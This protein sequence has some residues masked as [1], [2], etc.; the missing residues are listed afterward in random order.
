[1]TRILLSK[2]SSGFRK[3]TLAEKWA[4]NEYERML[5]EIGK[6]TD[7]T[8]NDYALQFYIDGCP[9]EKARKSE[10]KS[11][12]I[13]TRDD[14]R[15]KLETH[16]LTDPISKMRL[17]DIK[18]PDC[19]N[20]RD[21]LIDKLG[22]SR[23]AELSL[24]TFRNVIHEALN[25]GLINNDPTIK[26]NIKAKKGKRAATTVEGIKNIL[27]KKYWA[28]NTI[29]LAAMTAA[30]TGLRASEL[31]GLLWQHIDIKNERI[32]ILQAFVRG[33]GLKSTK[34]GRPR[35][36]IYPKVL[37]NILEPYRGKPDSYVF[38]I[39]D[40]EPLAYTAIRSAMRRAMKKAVKENIEKK[41][42]EETGNTAVTNG[43][44][45]KNVTK[46]TLHGLRHSI[47]TAL[48]ESG[49]N[50]ELLRASFG[51]V[52]K[53]TQEGYTHRELFDLTPQK[54]ATEKLFQGFI[55]E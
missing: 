43:D 40:G 24:V 1:M 11:F 55:G 23:T 19:I 17:Y 9:H 39:K 3:Q 7:M 22:Y 10:G 41:K 53:E 47:N 13:W 52:D 18:R 36:T 35:M 45:E 29:W 4:R 33:D 51:W 34:S 37:Q 54:E 2:K 32:N 14:Y 20:L 16:I 26:V 49:V 12:G 5:N 46:I 28:N 27:L 31:S 21:R 30:I 42:Q 6:A 8:F 50:P 44:M 25:R 38:S 15:R 48:L